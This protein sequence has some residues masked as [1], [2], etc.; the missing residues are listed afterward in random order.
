MFSPASVLAHSAPR[1][2]CENGEEWLATQAG[3]GTLQATFRIGSNAGSIAFINWSSFSTV[4]TL[5]PCS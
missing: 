4:G 3:A 5:L 1:L 2:D